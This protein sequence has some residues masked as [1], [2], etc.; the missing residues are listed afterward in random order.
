MLKV[1][2]QNDGKIKFQSE[3]SGTKEM[4]SNVNLLLA[5][6]S[7]MEMEK[8]VNKDIVDKDVDNNKVQT[9]HLLHLIKVEDCNKLST[10]RTLSLQLNVSLRE[11]K[12]IVDAAVDGKHDTLLVQSTDLDFINNVRNALESVGCTC[13]ITS[14]V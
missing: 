2:I 7:S 6:V 13:K 12:V 1:V 4:R 5:I 11:A 8:A 9:N 14:D 10:V 3:C